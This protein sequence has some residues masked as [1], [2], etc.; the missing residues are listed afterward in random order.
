[1]LIKILVATHFLILAMP[2]FGPSI[3]QFQP[4]KLEKK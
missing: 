1:M 3:Q 4:Q 2:V